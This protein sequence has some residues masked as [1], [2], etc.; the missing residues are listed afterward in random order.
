ME[1]ICRAHGC[2]AD[3]TNR[4]QGD[5]EG[6]GT[7]CGKVLYDLLEMRISGLEP[8]ECRTFLAPKYAQDE[9]I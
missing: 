9:H 5:L 1:T 8:A 6:A 2:M 4:Y 3:Q 7:P